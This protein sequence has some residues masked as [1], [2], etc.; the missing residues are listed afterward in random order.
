MS[1]DRNDLPAEPTADDVD[2][3]LQSFWNGSPAALDRLIGGAVGS[4]ASVGAAL[5]ALT[6][7]GSA[8]RRPPPSIPGYRIVRELGRGGMAVVYEAVQEA[9]GQAVALKRV[10]A[11]GTVGT[12]WSSRLLEREVRTLGRLRH[13]GIAALYDAGRDDDACHYFVMELVAGRPITES[14]RGPVR[15]AA[16][17]RRRL[18]LFLEVCAAVDYAHQRG[19]IHCDLKPTNVLVDD[20]GRPRVLDFG[21]A[22]LLEADSGRTIGVSAIGPV[23][24]LSH[25]S[26]EQTAG[27]FDAID[28]RTDVYSLGV[29]LFELLTGDRPYAVRASALAEAVRTICELP[30]RR[31]SSLAPLV[32]GD[33]ETIILKALAKS[34]EQRYA[35]VAAL[36]ADVERASQGR[37]I[38]ARPPTIGYVVGRWCARHR[39]PTALLALLAGLIATFGGV[40]VGKNRELAAQRDKA[41]A[42]SVRLAQANGFLAD[43][44]AT[45]DPRVVG[46]DV[47]VRAILDHAA[48]A[49]DAALPD[50]PAARAELHD[51]I[52][53]GYFALMQY[54]QAVREHARAVDLFRRM[55]GDADPR[56][57][58]ALEHYGLAL[59]SHSDRATAERALRQAYD[60]RLALFGEDDPATAQSL[61]S[62]AEFH[63]YYDFAEAE[64][65][66]RRALDI[67]TRLSPD[68]MLLADTRYALGRLFVDA[69]RFADA[70]PLLTQALDAHVKSGETD[71]YE[72]ARIYSYLGELHATRGDLGRAERDY[73]EQIRILEKISG[74]RSHRDWAHGMSDLAGVL[75]D[76]GR[77]DE[78]DDFHQRAVAMELDAGTDPAAALTRHNYAAFLR[79]MARYDEAEAL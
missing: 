56:T 65:L 34:P 7:I 54:P 51:T 17:L 62:L 32:R 24:T 25:M 27:R 43:L 68:P 21:L 67:R 10:P 12:D 74:G 35:G 46:A 60:I 57:A 79:D 75:T 33:I 47:S 53:R 69:G 66:L 36:A 31:P 16:D 63:H 64:R 76:L 3:A 5:N 6:R 39:L 38:L 77:V 40:L 73:H 23:G 78:A 48:E 41:R 28:V 1:I 45:V 30:P 19:V 14:A 2:G 49:I 42:E 59:L 15:D 18:A 58:A 52:G 50:Q 72:V 37:P 8:T 44:F 11:W 29:M 70:E 22:R 55:H 13:P 71:R 9:T 26:P 61:C 4:S 20:A